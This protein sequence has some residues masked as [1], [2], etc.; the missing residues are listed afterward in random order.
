MDIL[1]DKNTGY[2]QM[3]KQIE[4]LYEKSNEETD[5]FKYCWRGDTLKNFNS[6]LRNM[7]QEVWIQ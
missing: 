5:G 6:L 3:V 1:R 7:P 4:E 2:L